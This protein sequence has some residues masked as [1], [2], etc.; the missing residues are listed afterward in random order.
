MAGKINHWCIICGKGYHA[1]DDCVKIRSFKPWRTLAD[2]LE[3]F[4]IYMTIQ[5]YND[6]IINKTKA[7]AELGNVDLSDR[8]SYKDNVKKVL[9]EIF[10]ED[11]PT[12][13]GAKKNSKNINAPIDENELSVSDSKADEKDSE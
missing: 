13:K 12:Q 3:H 5:A 9:D 4:Q 10:S 11:V 8:D 1:C 2:T 7:Q 6:K